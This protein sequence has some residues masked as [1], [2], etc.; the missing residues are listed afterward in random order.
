[1]AILP[2]KKIEAV[3]SYTLSVF[4]KETLALIYKHND[5]KIAK[6]AL[7]RLKVVV[8]NLTLESFND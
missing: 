4:Q 8:K 7:K 5:P 2:K 3:V 1:M 6:E